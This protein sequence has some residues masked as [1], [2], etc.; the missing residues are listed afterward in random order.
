[1][2]LKNI[3]KRQCTLFMTV[4]VLLL[5]CDGDEAT[6]P[7]PLTLAATQ[8]TNIILGEVPE[9]ALLNGYGDWA[10]TLTL[11]EERTY[12]IETF[13]SAI[14]KWT[15]SG[16]AITITSS[17]VTNT[18]TIKASALGSANLSVTRDANGGGTCGRTGTI[19]VKKPGSTTPP[20]PTCSCPAPVIDDQLCVTGG[21]PYWRFALTGISDTDEIYWYGNHISVMSGQGGTY[22]VAN[23]DGTG[24]FTLYCRVTRRC[25]NGV[26]SSRTAY[27]TNSLNAQCNT[28]RI[29]FTGTCGSGPLD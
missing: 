2:L 18:V 19:T 10:G 13:P 1:M 9:C 3:I 16:S 14:Y 11:G 22:V 29:G 4:F 27:Y 5:A 24:D 25:S 15:T 26:T 6:S 7:K 12:A 21:H 20:T 28:G 17:D 8:G 23:P